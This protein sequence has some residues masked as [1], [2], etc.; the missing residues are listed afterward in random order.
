M[1]AETSKKHENIVCKDKDKTKASPFAGISFSTLQRNQTTI[2]VDNKNF[3]FP[4]I[5]D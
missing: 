3:Q 5:T 2:F 4:V 1:L